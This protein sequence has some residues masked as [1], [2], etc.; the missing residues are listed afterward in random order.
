ME[1]ISGQVELR[2][3]ENTIKFVNKSQKYFASAQP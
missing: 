3:D 2:V 1:N